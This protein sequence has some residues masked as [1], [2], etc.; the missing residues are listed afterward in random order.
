MLDAVFTDTV[1][2][3]PDFLCKI[4]DINNLNIAGETALFEH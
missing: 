1:N 4:Q 2:L 3:E